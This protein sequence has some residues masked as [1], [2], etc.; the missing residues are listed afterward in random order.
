MGGRS[1]LIASGATALTIPYSTLGGGLVNADEML[2][3]LNITLFGWPF[4]F[5]LALDGRRA[6]ELLWLAL[7]LLQQMVQGARSDSG[8]GRTPSCETRKLRFLRWASLLPV[9][10]LN[11]SQAKSRERATAGLRHAL[12]SPARAS[13]LPWLYLKVRSRPSNWQASIV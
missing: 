1:L 7:E 10:A 2:T 12:A 5:A 4:Y 11:T 6:G 13:M 8:A 9:S 3:S